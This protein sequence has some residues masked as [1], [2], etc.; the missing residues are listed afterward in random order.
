MRKL[1]LVF[2]CLLYISIAKAQTI[3]EFQ[4]NFETD[5]YELTPK[6]AAKIDAILE[7]IKANINNLSVQ[8]IGH[9]DNVGDL[10]YNYVLSNNR[11]KTVADYIQNKGFNSNKIYYSG[12]SYLK[13][14]CK[15][16]SEIGK[17]KNRRVTLKIYEE[18]NNPSIN[19]LT[20]KEESYK[21]N[22]TKK[23]TIQYKSGTQITIPENAFVDKNGKD[24]V[25]TVNISYIEYREPVDF[26]LGNITMDYNDGTENHHFN[27]AGMFKIY[28]TQ[29]G[30]NVTLKDGKNITFNFQKTQEL[31][32]LNFYQLDDTTKKWKELY[33]FNNI[34]TN[35]YQAYGNDV[36]D[37]NNVTGEQTEISI[38]QLNGCDAFA[39]VKKI[40]VNYSEGIDLIGRNYNNQIKK[41]VAERK[42]EERALETLTES[43]KN[44]IE[45]YQKRISNFDKRIKNSQPI[46][47]ATKIS[48][49]GNE[50]VFNIL[51]KVQSNVQNINFKNTNWLYN[52]LKNGK[53]NPSLYTQNWKK[54]T[55]EAN[56]DATFS[57]VLQDSISE[58]SI[59][60]VTMINP[61]VSSDQ[62]IKVSNSMNN[63]NKIQQSR[64]KKFLRNKERFLKNNEDVTQILNEIESKKKKLKDTISN[65]MNQN[66]IVCFW[67]KSKPYM[68]E[69]EAKLPIQ[70]WLNYFDK[71]K[72]PMLKRY[73]NLPISEDCNKRTQQIYQ[74]QQKVAENRKN[75]S[76]AENAAADLKQSLQ[77]SKLGIYNCDQIQRLQNPVEIFANYADE[78]GKE[79]NPVFI[80]LLDSNF[81]GIIKYDG[82]N[83]LSPYR[84]AYSP[85]SKNTIIA[86]DG[87]G[88]S[89]VYQSEKFNEI[90]WSGVYKHHDFVL[91]KIE[92]LKNISELKNLL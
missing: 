3:K 71:N 56:D 92:N 43:Y 87:S 12:R 44:S 52:T 4:V 50:E 73:S 51:F 49:D 26:L 90:N 66:S 47:T 55:I 84:F 15:N 77:I 9:T 70:D 57:I 62:L 30:E 68:S 41:K 24:V 63:S 17:A 31:P 1:Y 10:D 22:G 67:E 5:S 18:K 54:C 16:N 89:Y 35:F 60:N 11:A 39:A 83:G 36:I 2:I 6:E 59:K 75:T 20:L 7:P 80:Y 38:C 58:I 37:G 53:L 27:S 88:N 91:K 32:N 81:N 69:E 14:I 45:E 40:G 48:N 23:E 78:K 76:T 64:I 82:Y 74:A 85:Q 8:I 28:A 65:N 72:E 34:T 42:S 13:P 61:N 25:G 19:G 86:F 46:Y 29:N 79:V 33:S 21:I